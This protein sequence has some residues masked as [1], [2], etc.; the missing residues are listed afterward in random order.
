MVAFGMHSLFV[1]QML[2]SWPSGYSTNWRDLVTAVLK[3]GPQLQQRTWWKDEARTTGQR[4]RVTG[5]KISQNQILGEDNYADVQRQSTY[6]HT[7]ALCHAAALNAWD[8]IEEV[9]KRTESFTKVVQGP[10]ETFTNFFK[11]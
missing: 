11:D 8:R 1:R 7:L 5:I 9:R 10:K 3:P 4:S 2:N 6:D